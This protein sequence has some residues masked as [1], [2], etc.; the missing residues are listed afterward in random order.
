M[1][2]KMGLKRW[3]PSSLHPAAVLNRTLDP[4]LERRH[5]IPPPLGE[6][7]LSLHRDNNRALAELIDE[8]LG[9]YGYF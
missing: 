4:L 8:D 6:A 7:A 5:L 2:I 9:R 3:I 1:P